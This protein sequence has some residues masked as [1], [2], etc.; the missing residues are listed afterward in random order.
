VA[1]AVAE[2]M[3]KHRPPPSKRRAADQPKDR[4][5]CPEVHAVLTEK[6]GVNSVDE[7]CVRLPRGLGHT[8]VQCVNCWKDEHA[9]SRQ[10]LQNECLK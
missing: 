1:Q 8:I 9:R 10:Q 4:F 5:D 2:V 3:N 7:L 6:F